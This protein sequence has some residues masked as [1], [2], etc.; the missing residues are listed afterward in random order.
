MALNRLDFLQSCGYHSSCGGLSEQQAKGW[1]HYFG[2]QF[3]YIHFLCS[4]AEKKRLLEESTEKWNTTYPKNKDC[5]WKIQTENGRV[6]CPKPE[7]KSA[8]Q[9]SRTVSTE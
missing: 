8:V 7:F 4:D 6:S 3:R 9:F 2:K 5:E 1:K